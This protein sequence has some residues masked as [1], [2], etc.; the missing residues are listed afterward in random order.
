VKAF[1]MAE[2]EAYYTKGLVSKNQLK[3]YRS[4]H[5]RRLHKGSKG[6]KANRKME[7]LTTAIWE[8]QHRHGSGSKH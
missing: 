3:D 4:A 2:V 1:T 5:Q 8:K 7:Q 6:A